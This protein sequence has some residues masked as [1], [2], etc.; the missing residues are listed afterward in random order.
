MQ[1]RG[2]NMPVLVVEVEVGLERLQKLALVQSAEEHRLVDRD[3]PVGE[4]VY[5]ALVR[6][7]AAR[8]DERSPDAHS[9]TLVFSCRALKLVERL[10][11]RLERTRLQRRQGVQSLMA[12]KSFQPVL[13]VDALGLVRE[14]HGVPIERNAHFVRMAACLLAG[15]RIHP[16]CRNARPERADYVAFVRGEE[17]IGFQR[18][19]ITV[20][21]APA[22]EDAALD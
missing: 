11:K 5:G 6:R 3:F 14:Q 21:A 10:E 22:G 12:G 16:G 4:G 8:S 19:E 2:I 20:R 17:E 18:I 13:L 1:P 7:R 15:L 9:R